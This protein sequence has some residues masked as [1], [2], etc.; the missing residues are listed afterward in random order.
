MS[1]PRYSAWRFLHPDI[2]A[3]EA[4]AGLTV[5]AAG[6]IDTVAD[7]ASVRQAILL[8]LSTMLGERVMRPDYGCELHR[9]VFSPND[10]TTAG[11]AIH[12]VRQ[13]LERWEPRIDIVRLD[14]RRNERQPTWLDLSLE[15]RVRPTQ[16]VDA[17]VLSLNLA[18][19][20]R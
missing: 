12:Y 3:P 7:Q 13:A 14:A 5:S 16:R 8:V 9:L 17:L 19:E 18:G 6:R 15:Y 4:V 10:D 2:D 20:E 1:I 11:L